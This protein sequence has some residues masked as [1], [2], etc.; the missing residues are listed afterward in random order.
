MARNWTLA[1]RGLWEIAIA[2]KSTTLISTTDQPKWMQEQAK[3]KYVCAWTSAPN[4]AQLQMIRP[5][6][7]IQE[8]WKDT[9]YMLKQENGIEWMSGPIKDFEHGKHHTN[10]IPPWNIRSE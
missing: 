3:A 8:E 6:D 10:F 1:P 7:G 2:S 5:G 4:V 9:R